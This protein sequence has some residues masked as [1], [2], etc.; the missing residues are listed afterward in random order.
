MTEIIEDPFKYLG[1]PT[2][3]VKEEVDKEL[4]NSED[5]NSFFDLLSSTSDSTKRGIDSNIKILNDLSGEVEKEA[6]EQSEIRNPLKKSQAE[7]D[8]ENIPF[9]Q[10][11]Y[12]PSGMM[13]TIS[14]S[15]HYGDGVEDQYGHVREGFYKQSEDIEDAR[16]A[17]IK[18]KS[19]EHKKF[20][21][22]KNGGLEDNV[23]SEIG[24]YGD[25]YM[26]FEQLDIKNA[27]SEE[28]RQGLLKKYNYQS[29]TDTNGK[30]LRYV[31]T[32][33]AENVENLIQTT[34]KDVIED[35]RNQSFFEFKSAAMNF[36]KATN[37]GYGQDVG[38]VDFS[39]DI[40][41]EDHF[42]TGRGIMNSTGLG[43]YGDTK[44]FIELF[45]K[46]GKLPAGISEIPG[47]S[48]IARQF[49]EALTNFK[50]L[51]I[52]YEANVDMGVAPQENFILEAFNGFRQ[53]NLDKLSQAFDGLIES[54]GFKPAGDQMTRKQING[55]F[56]NLMEGGRDIAV[57]LAP[58]ALSVAAFKKIP[59]G[60][61]QNVK[62]GKKAWTLSM[63]T[64]SAERALNARVN[65]LQKFIVGSSNSMVFR[66]VVGASLAGIKEIAVL[67]G[68]DVIGKKAFDADPFVYNPKTGD[69]DPTF[70]GS[71][72][73]GNFIAGKALNRLMQKKNIF[74]KPFALAS[75]SKVISTLANST[76]GA[77][78]GTATLAFSQIMDANAT[79]LWEEGEF[80]SAEEMGEFLTKQKLGETFIGM[81]MFGGKATLSKLYNGMRVDILAM[82]GSTISSRR[83]SK[84]LNIKE[85]SS[86]EEI[87]R[88]RKQAVKEV[89]ESN[90]DNKAKKKKVQEIN[91]D[92]RDLQAFN[93]NTAAKKAAVQ[94]GKYNDQLAKLFVIGNKIEANK[95]LN[96]EEI[97]SFNNLKEHEF[98]LLKAKLGAT[99][100][101]DLSRQLDNQ[102]GFYKEII[103][104]VD[105]ARIKDVDSEERKNLIND[106]IKLTEI[107]NKIQE[108]KSK[109]KESNPAFDIMNN[110]EV[111][112]LKIE[113]E[114]VG[115]SVEKST[116]SYD[117]ALKIKMQAEVMIA[118]N[119]AAGFGS[120]F[121]IMPDAKFKEIYGEGDGVFVEGKNGKKG[122]I[123]INKEEALKKRQLGTPIH[124]V[125]HL[126]LKNHLKESYT[127]AKGKVRKRVSEQGIKFINEFKEKLKPEE[128][129]AVEKRIEEEYRYDENGK[130]R[131][132]N[133]YYEEY[134]TVFGDVLKNN[135]VKQ[136][137]S[138]GSRISD[139]FINLLRSHGFN[140]LN[141]VGVNSGE[142]L[143]NMIKAIQ[144]GDVGF[145][146]KT[147]GKGSFVEGESVLKSKTT[148]AFEIDKIAADLGLSKTTEKTVEKNKEIQKQILEEGLKDSQ[149]NTIASKAQQNKL[150]ENNM[151]RV[152]AL[153]RKAAGQANNLTLEEG[154]KMNDVSEW[155]SSY[156]MKLIDLARTYKAERVVDKNGD[157]LAKPEKIPF[158][159]YMNGLLPKKYSGILEN[160]KSKLE[161]SSMSNET[162]AKKVSKMTN[163][164]SNKALDAE[165]GK[166][167][168]VKEVSIVNKAKGE[169]LI[170]HGNDV[171]KNIGTIDLKGKTIKNIPDL[172]PL[173]TAEFFV[174]GAVY[175]EGK[176]I[177]KKM[178]GKPIAPE[179]ARKVLEN[180]D[181]NVQDIEA[182]HNV[183]NKMASI[184]STSL[185]EGNLGEG[186]GF[187]STGQGK[188][189]LEPFYNKRS[190]RAKTG[191]GPKYQTKKPVIDPVEFKEV[192]GVKKDGNTALKYENGQ[193]VKALVR[194]WGKE[195]T[196]QRIKLIPEFAPELAMYE[197]I[198]KLKTDISIGRGS[199]VYSRTSIKDINMLNKEGVN[200]ET[201]SKIV[202]KNV[203]KFVEEQ[204]KKARG[205]GLEEKV[206]AIDKANR[207][208]LGLTEVE[209]KLF[210]KSAATAIAKISKGLG[211]ES[212]RTSLAN[213]NKTAALIEQRS[214]HNVKV[215]NNLPFDIRQLP[216]AAVYALTR[217]LGWSSKSRKEMV[218]GE[219]LYL[220]KNGKD[221]T[222]TTL[223]YFGAK[224]IKSSEAKYDGRYDA[225]FSPKNYGTLKRDINKERTK[226]E[227]NKDYKNQAERDMALVDYV[228]SKFSSDKTSKGF[229]ATETANKALAR[230][231]YI[232][233]FIAA[234]QAGKLGLENILVDQGMQSNHS[235]G[236]T[237]SMLYNL[238]S[239]SRYGSEP[240]KYTFE[241]KEYETKD[242]DHWEHER[243]LLNTTEHFVRLVK[244][245][246]LEVNKETGKSEVTDAFLNDL[247]LLIE[248]SQ[249]SLVKKT[250]QLK[251]D[252]QGNTVYSKQYSGNM[253]DNAIMN[254]LTV[255]GEASNQLM[256][257]GKYKGKSYSEVVTSE[258]TIE[259]LK[260]IVK[261]IPENQRSSEAFIINKT[262]VKKYNEMLNNNINIAKQV[263]ISYSKTSNAKNLKNI[264]ITKKAFE[265]GKVYNKV[266]RG[267]STFDF[268]K[269]AGD[270]DNF[271]FAEK[272]KLKKKISADNWP[273]V[274]EKLAK[275]GWKFDFT[276]FNKVTNG[277]PGPLMQ[278]L[279]NQIKKYGN[280]NVFI[281][282]AR[283]PESAKA[284][285]DFLKSEGAELPLKNITGLG[286]STGEAK[287]MWMLKK[288]SEGYND[289]Y[290]VD[291]AMP[292]VKA[293]KNVLEQLDIKSSVQLARQKSITTMSDRFNEI[294]ELTTGVK[295]E[296]TF[297][298][299]KA[300]VMGKSKKSKSIIV[301]G[302]Q[303][304]KGLLQNFEGKGKEGEIHRKF[305]EDN[306]HEPFSK[307]YNEI[308]IAKQAVTSEYSTLTKSMRDVSKKLSKTLPNSPWTY[309]QAVRVHRWTEA[310]FEIPELSKGD[311][312]ELNNAVNKNVEL[313]AF[314]NQ[315]AKIT[316]QEQGYTKPNQ[317]WIAES[318]ISDLNGMV[319]TVNREGFM[320]DFI[321][322]REQVFGKWSGGKLKG[323][324]INKIE[325]TQGPKF[326]DAL[327]DILW[328]METGNNRPSGSN[329]LVNQHM[330][331]I[332][333]SVG[334]TMFFNTKSA[335]LQSL[336]TLN[337]INW[338]DNNPIKAAKAFAN[339]P[340]YWKDFAMI[341]NSPMLKQRR[342]GLKYNVSEAELAQAAASTGGN[343]L[344]KSKAVLAR[345]L[346]LGFL[347]TQI[348]DSFAISA[349][350]S[351]FYRNK[352]NKYLK[353]GLSKSKAESQ[354]FL[355]FQEKTEVAQQS[356]RPDLIS[357]QQAGAMGRT[358]LAWANTPMQYARLQEKAARDLLN[359]RG[360]KKEH[361][362]KLA[363]YGVAQSFLFAGLQ[364][365]MFGFLLDDEYDLEKD[366][367]EPN[368]ELNKRL[369]RVSN[370]VIDSQLRGIG[371]PGALVSTVKNMA[372]EG[373]AQNK[374]DYNADY[375]KVAYQAVSYSPPLGS[376]VRKIAS[377]GNMW[378]F[379]K[380]EIM[381]MGLTLDNPGILA[382]ANV[383]EA[384]T[385]A[386]AARVIN[387]TD[388]IREFLDEQNQWWQRIF[389]FGGFA[390]WDLGTE[391]EALVFEKKLNKRIKKN[392]RK[393]GRIIQ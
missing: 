58:L 392:K 11:Y 108:L 207:E 1:Q 87:R 253:A 39:V 144:K 222:E 305:F 43:G 180:K 221:W 128:L 154:L 35:M 248:T 215:L 37:P 203:K 84:R 193:P 239:I 163:E 164:N 376:K 74:T 332:N 268:D 77:T 389:A 247:D 259:Q 109:S 101:T 304:F 267:M 81:T 310:G 359:K 71:L 393:A 31:P 158:G 227:E 269:T 279:K 50:T 178:I 179:L 199:G 379:N 8:A 98:D 85:G 34:D 113:A 336:S 185:I 371:I 148:D 42:T 195:I 107:G 97:E 80:S 66:N 244:K 63:E 41:P 317:N 40:N 125:G 323:A 91:N 17:D 172:S 129:E 136:T 78:I 367:K 82:Q 318:I 331:F 260:N 192:F 93:E 69:F 145:V 234:K 321:S 302:A 147:I 346:K 356:S 308:N 277:R 378:K 95:K 294:V 4:T 72:G 70:A 173:K 157:K 252:A 204:Y 130:R 135:E 162:T 387:K 296:A 23:S 156:S 243:Q 5:E 143:F 115:L 151:G 291:D 139:Q 165:Q 300:K 33:V 240:G 293:V 281:L 159:A 272:G 385:N 167:I 344:E 27:S 105:D 194:A 386:P 271:I 273:F 126:I 149:G 341:M 22:S 51:N 110:R 290:F 224:E 316:R 26:D 319:S 137:S 276:D 206:G 231:L 355:D 79:K 249:Q 118:K 76:T 372:M 102:K 169:K 55:S 236:I 352:V 354:A 73:V 61:I 263:G 284:I 334:A 122:K 47:K 325:A 220:N 258:Y 225:V 358:V 285:F 286:N 388:N 142:G 168:Y 9:K 326:R 132:D 353:E 364:N 287:A 67:G 90:L 160:M 119:I 16:R 14:N 265:L 330:D 146:A 191:P 3:K 123:I 52:A 94:A 103:S 235:T 343:M 92:A 374:K 238:R 24:G 384:T 12:E 303:D 121:E 366:I 182:T 49:N 322:N 312:K 212:A 15:P 6:A 155:N 301:P 32:L 197:N 380:D 278:K 20:Y 289:M 10:L 133:E 246:K 349:G 377:A 329:W 223:R 124:E 297:S 60:L 86:I 298:G 174:G 134:L 120:G 339:Q 106:L 196:R 391:N 348:M 381:S 83:A 170:E 68:A 48:P 327:E 127:D 342:S 232:A 53:N 112:K 44:K 217:E 219:Q 264:K 261:T 368:K 357:Q 131:K 140:N 181:L 311:I 152:Y 280:E 337:Y 274:G 188:A 138:L 338:S 270:S 56:A 315:L 171:V 141:T 54:A 229:E 382:A 2:L 7:L 254:V 99:K 340:Q 257:S 36:I 28:E 292:N 314:S 262:S 18:I 362:S 13:G 213:V 309:D 275:E 288:F 335:T 153:A 89:V 45:L 228:R 383:V 245:H 25:A 313:L 59:V 176:G 116:K 307:A 96:N 100:G 283:A 30:F 328:R 88:T 205:L 375:A 202:D 65:L 237:K 333:G 38:V 209:Y 345:L 114:K 211:V 230:D 75:Q 161:T 187:K 299:A 210:E 104:I 216:P 266:S 111:E 175:K 208:D 183:I 370:T 150:I 295:K 200:A 64:V 350:G 324:N 166:M 255:K 21:L 218:G 226:I 250:L 19:K 320:K 390:K 242:F 186:M 233:K 29:L 306:F 282:T 373:H 365:A 177:L 351:S 201:I 190:V 360:D 241:G 198:N 117:K 347:P 189:L 214:S 46:T 361:V 369:W 363:Y 62:K 256:M 184:L 251:N 57:H